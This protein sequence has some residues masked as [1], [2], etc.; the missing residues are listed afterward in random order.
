MLT[1]FVADTRTNAQHFY[2]PQTLRVVGGTK[3]GL[4]SIKTLDRD[5]HM[6]TLTTVLNK[7][8]ESE[9]YEKIFIVYGFPCMVFH[10]RCIFLITTAHVSESP[11]RLRR[12]WDSETSG[13]KSI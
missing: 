1:S 11:S 7:I 8:G 13:D 2:V 10:V 9:V 6:Q 5:K 4:N 3:N 12:G